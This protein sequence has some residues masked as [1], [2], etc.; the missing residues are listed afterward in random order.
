MRHDSEILLVRGLLDD[1]MVRR[2]FQRRPVLVPMSWSRPESTEHEATEMPI[3]SGP[4]PGSTGSGWLI[5]LRYRELGRQQFG[6][7]QT[8][9]ASKPAS[10]GY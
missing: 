6:S 2:L 9:L 8:Q 10:R 1:D 7:Q 3:S 5:H 4:E